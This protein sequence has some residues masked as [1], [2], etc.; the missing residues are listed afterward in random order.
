MTAADASR[1]C[2]HPINALARPRAAQLDPV[3]A[4]PA[5]RFGAPPQ[6][7]FERCQSA[8]LSIAEPTITRLTM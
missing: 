6:D 5:A 7:A 8:A 4:A 3:M 2:A 1:G